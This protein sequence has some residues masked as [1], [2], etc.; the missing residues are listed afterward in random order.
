MLDHL[1]SLGPEGSISRDEWA[2]CFPENFEANLALALKRDLVE[3]ENGF[4]H[5]QV[6]MIRRWFA[7]RPF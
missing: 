2:R 7:Y 6:E 4:Y 1:S 5:F 3:D